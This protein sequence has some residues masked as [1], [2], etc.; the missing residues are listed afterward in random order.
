MGVQKKDDLPHHLWLAE[1]LIKKIKNNEFV[2]GD[3]IPS[4]MELSRKFGVSRY[5]VRQAIERVAKL[6]WVTTVKGKGSYVRTKPEVIPYS[7]SEMTRFTNNMNRIGKGYKS[8]LLR[9]K[10]DKPTSE[11]TQALQL[12]PDEQVYRLEILRY[13]DG[14]PFSITTSVLCEK[15]VPRMERYLE[16]FNSLYAIL[17]RY[18]N[19]IPVRVRS[20]F[21]ATFAEL[22]DIA[23]LEISEGLPILK[24]KSF[25]CHPT[26]YPVEYSITRV[27]G[28]MSSCQIEFRGG[29]LRET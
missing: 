16:N 3:K 28:D 24:I 14:T 21:E 15:A 22:K 6:G 4:E 13:V 17:D 1:Q 29:V 27:R 2:A 11:E 23:Y 9:W 19:F 12:M 20:V 5:A 26:G 7:I 25:M 18:Y 8:L 10:K